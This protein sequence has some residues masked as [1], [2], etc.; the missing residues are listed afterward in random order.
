MLPIR[1]TDF[2]LLRGLDFPLFVMQLLR[3]TFASQSDVHLAVG[4]DMAR[5]LETAGCGPDISQWLCGIDTEVFNPTRC[6]MAVTEGSLRWRLTGGRPHLP[7]VLYCGRVAPEKRLELMPQLM[8]GVAARL[9]AAGGGGVKGA[10]LGG[11]T[12][13]VVIVGAGPS[14][15]PLKALMSD[16]GP[17]VDFSSRGGCFSASSPAPL[18]SHF[19]GTA[20]AVTTFCG[21][22]LHGDL[23]GSIYATCDAFASPSTCET[24]GQVFQE[25]MAA[26]TVP[27]GADFGGACPRKMPSRFARCILHWAHYA[28]LSS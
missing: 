26:G 18:V 25:A 8:R 24:L 13:A 11:P 20:V 28:Q 16:L 5:H 22:M 12:V 4:S 15:D 2:P 6:S 21:S 17:I 14:L 27:T 23:L 9:T 7:I 1:F 10:G 3:R 19:S